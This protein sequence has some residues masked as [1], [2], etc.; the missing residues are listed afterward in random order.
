MRVRW[1]V[2]RHIVEE[3]GD[4]GAVVEIEA[5]KEILVGLA[6]AGVLRDDEAGNRLQ[7]FSRAKNRTILDFLCA[8]RSLG[9]R[10][11]NSDKII[12]PALHIDGRA[13]RA[14][15]Q[16]DAQRGRRTD[17]PYGDKDFFG[18]K[19]GIRYDESIIAC[20]ESG[21]NE[22]TV[23]IRPCR[24]LYSAARGLNLHGSPCNHRARRVN[25]SS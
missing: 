22:R 5:A 15:Y 6:A 16:R 2:K 10:F 4:I 13:H 14:H 3:N 24:F 23:R 18:F 17:G 19:T 8:H 21:K 12:L 20:R 9:A 1:Q 7:Y 11:G 25:D